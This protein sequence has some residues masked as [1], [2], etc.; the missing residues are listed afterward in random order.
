MNFSPSIMFHH[1]YDNVV[2]PY[3]QGALL[4]LEFDAL[5][6]KIKSKKNLMPA[7][8][9]Y[10]NFKNNTL[11]ENDICLT[12][13]DTLKSQIDIALPILKQHHLNAFFFLYTSPF[14]NKI[15]LL[16][17]FRYFRN[18]YYSDVELYYKDFF[19]AIENLSYYDVIKDQYLN[20][21]YS[22]HLSPYPF[23]TFNDRK[24]RYV[25]DIILSIEQYNEIVNAI[26]DHSQWD[27]TLYLKNIWM[28][29]D[30]VKTLVDAGHLIGMH[31]HTHPTKLTRL[32]KQ[33]QQA[34]YQ[35][36][37]NFLKSLTGIEP[38]SAAH[39]VNSYNS[40]TISILNTMQVNLAFRSNDDLAHVTALEM[41]RMDCTIAK[42]IFL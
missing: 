33:E 39:P 36:N 32:S 29:T 9:W 24:Y 25:R 13:D 34:E 30:D 6:T 31:T 7:S 40:D 4:G 21:D 5:I 35:I 3:I 1:L 41:P 15:E 17:Y 37:S 2:H 23:Y 26:I 27:K 16:E 11:G 20:T 8:D 42:K 28:N 19:L 22:T 38:T 18:T 14:D 10:K 12:F